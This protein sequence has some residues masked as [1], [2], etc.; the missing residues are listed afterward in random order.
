[1][2]LMKS[3]AKLAVMTVGG[4]LALATAACS[5]APASDSQQA[6]I[7]AVSPGAQAQ[8]GQHDPSRFLQH[9]DKNGDGKVQVAELPE[10][11]QQRLAAADTDK[12]G[13][14]SPEEMN[15]FHSKMKA[16]KFA[17]SDKNGDGALDATEVSPERWARIQVADADKDGKVTRAELE[18]ARATGV[19]PRGEHHR[20][21]HGH[22]GAERRN[23]DPQTM[24]QR[25]DK[26]GDGVLQASEV[27]ERMRGFFDKA[28]ANKDGSLTKDEIVQFRAARAAERANVAPKA[29]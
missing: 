28:D 23:F 21:R 17:K 8:Q 22:F 3:M 16:A 6:S 11:M 29:K 24:I 9:F 1:M 2:L 27:P 19:L 20:G 25:L 10:R 4:L 14:L 26:N 18:Q 7:S 5:G 15:A 13:V 12:D